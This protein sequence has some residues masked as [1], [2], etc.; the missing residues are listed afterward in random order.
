MTDVRI[1][2]RDGGLTTKIIFPGAVVSFRG[3][4]FPVNLLK[5]NP[6]LPYHINLNNSIQSFEFEFIRAIKS[7][8]SEKLE[9]VAFIEGH[10]EL[11]YYE[12]FDLSKELSLFFQVDRGAIQGNVDNLLE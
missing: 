12:V 9:K 5:N 4:D 3:T 8:I 10:N 7:L 2:R 6:A 1:K 11:N